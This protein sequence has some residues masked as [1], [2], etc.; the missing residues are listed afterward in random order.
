[1]MKVFQ[2]RS[3]FKRPY[4]DSLPFWQKSYEVFVC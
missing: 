2:R 1:V 3:K 4:G